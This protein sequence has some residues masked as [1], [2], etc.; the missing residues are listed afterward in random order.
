MPELTKEPDLKTLFGL[1]SKPGAVVK[2]SNER[3][4]KWTERAAF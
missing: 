4:I 1:I 3:Y 2:F